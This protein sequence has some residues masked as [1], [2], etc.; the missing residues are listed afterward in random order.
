M[1]IVTIVAGS[2][3]SALGIFGYVMTDSRSLT[4]LIPLW[5]GMALELCGALA[6]KPDLKKHAMHGASVVG[7][8]GVLGSAPGA[9]Q[10]LRQVLTGGDV[11]L[12]ISML[13]RTAMFVI[14]AVF[15][16]LCVW[17]FRNARARR[18]AAA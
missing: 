17:S 10:V 15:L 1:P 5:F 6:L 11:A 4:A 2:V 3:L 13:F 7:L 12:P 8:L 16:A 14:C 18:L 9:V